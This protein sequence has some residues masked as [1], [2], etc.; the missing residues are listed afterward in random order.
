MNSSGDSQDEVITR[1]TAV[2]R[3]MSDD[4]LID[5]ATTCSN[6]GVAL[7]AEI[8]LRKRYPKRRAKWVNA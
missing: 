6:R 7:A 3:L 1:Q 5:V 2:E 8:A 4:D